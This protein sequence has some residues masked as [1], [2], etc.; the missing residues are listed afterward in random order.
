MRSMLTKTV[1]IL[2]AACSILV[3]ALMFSTGLLLQLLVCAGVVC[4]PRIMLGPGCREG[5]VIA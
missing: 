4:A 1:A 5:N 3:L 2:W